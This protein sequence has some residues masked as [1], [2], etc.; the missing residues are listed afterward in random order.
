M[1]SNRRERRGTELGVL[2]LISY[3]INNN[4]WVPLVTLGTIILQILIYL[5]II[6]LPF[7]TKQTCISGANIL[8]KKKYSLLLTSAL[9]HGDDMHLYYNMT[10]FT[11]KGRYLENKYG[12]INFGL[13]ILCLTVLSSSFYIVTAYALYMFYE[14]DY[15]QLMECA[16]GFSGVLFALKVI[17]TREKPSESYP[18]LGLSLPAW[19]A[20]WAELV[21]IS[22][23]V[24]NASF[25]G[26]LAGILA[27]LLY[28]DTPVGSLLD[29]VFYWISGRKMYHNFRRSLSFGLP[30]SSSS[31]YR[32]HTYSQRPTGHH[33]QRQR[34]GRPPAYGFVFGNQ[35]REDDWGWEHNDWEYEWDFRR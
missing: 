11:I 2:L 22:I 34:S 35:Q 25:K 10:S 7:A 20:A 4:D 33:T 15:T 19:S 3:L 14:E 32:S 26:H 1:R 8:F 16:V 17:I 31:S 23:M 28:T 9:Q 29:S 6:T 24:P 30:F 27:G 5:R 12:P 21:L 18:I 13:L